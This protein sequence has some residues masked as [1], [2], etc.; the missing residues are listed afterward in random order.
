MKI[1]GMNIT[2]APKIPPVIH[3]K[4]YMNR[5]W[6]NS[7]NKTTVSVED[8]FANL[9]FAIIWKRSRVLSNAKTS[10][11]FEQGET[12]IPANKNN[13]MVFRENPGR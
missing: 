11:F 3:Q 10:L 8:A 2:K 7:F 1:F 13:S 6:S 5:F 12:N 4:D 9:T